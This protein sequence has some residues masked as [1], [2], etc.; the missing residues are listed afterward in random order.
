MKNLSKLLM[1][2][3]VV[4]VAASCDSDVK[5]SATVVD[6]QT[7]NNTRGGAAEAITAVNTYTLDG[8]Q[9]DLSKVEQIDLQM[10]EGAEGAD[11]AAIA[12]INSSLMGA[13]K[14]AQLLDVK[15]SM[16]EEP[17]EN[18]I[19]VFGIETNEQKDLTLQLY[20]EE[21]FQLAAHNQIAV[22]EGNN[23]KALNVN[24]L[25]NGS[26]TFRLTDAEGKELSRSVTIATK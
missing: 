18:G 7:T 5:P 10:M 3:A 25:D 21:G 9:L 20:D 14:E 15:F 13:E 26:Y 2:V 17:V 23:Y 6:T 12:N 4:I 1:L 19:F 24:S 11:A 8:V 22:N 16:S